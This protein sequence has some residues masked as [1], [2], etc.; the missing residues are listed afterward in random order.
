[1]VIAGR[2]K[3]GGVLGVDVLAAAAVGYL[4]RKARRVGRRADERVDQALDAGTDRVC[5]LVQRFVTGDPAVELLSTQAATGT[6]SER[7]LRRAEDAISEALE[8]DSSFAQTLESLVTELERVPGGIQVTAQS[9]GVAAGRDVNIR[10]EG[11]GIAAGVIGS[12][13][14]GPTPP[15]T[16]QP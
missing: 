10:A 15:G 1:M 12:V 3:A 13:R 6:E 14:T 4:I 7:T 16:S 9:G 11:G 5:D 8:S 2:G